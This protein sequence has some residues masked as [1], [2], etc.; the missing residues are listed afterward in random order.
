MTVNEDI[1]TS[2]YITHIIN[3]D[4]STCRLVDLSTCQPI[5]VDNNKDPVDLD[6]HLHLYIY[7]PHTGLTTC[8]SVVWSSFRPTAVDMK[9]DP[10]PLP[11]SDL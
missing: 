7:T 2:I 9:E 10:S 6:H 5:S 4:L 3:T 1:Y 11:V 8:V